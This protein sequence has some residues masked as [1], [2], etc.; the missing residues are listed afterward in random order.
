MRS[1]DLLVVLAAMEPSRHSDH[2]QAE[3]LLPLSWGTDLRAVV[4]LQQEPSPDKAEQHDP[5]CLC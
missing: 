1:I 4:K 2:Q 3:Q 5:E